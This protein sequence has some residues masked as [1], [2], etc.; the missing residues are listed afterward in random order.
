MLQYFEHTPIGKQMY[1]G[2][3]FG[4][5]TNISIEH[6]IFS[7]RLAAT[8]TPCVIHELAANRSM[9]FNIKNLH[10]CMYLYR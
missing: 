7:K 1:E 10:A 4:I 3:P 5:E 9:V 6:N 2:N 8:Y